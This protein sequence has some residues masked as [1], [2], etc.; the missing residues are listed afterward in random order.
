[1]T[2]PDPHAGSRRYPWRGMRAKPKAPVSTRA[3]TGLRA[4]RA[5][6]LPFVW[7]APCMSLGACCRAKEDMVA[8]SALR[9]CRGSPTD[10]TTVKIAG[11]ID[12]MPPTDFG[13]ASKVRRTVLRAI[14]C[15]YFSGDSEAPATHSGSPSPGV[16]SRRGR[17]R[18]AC[19]RLLRRTACKRWLASRAVARL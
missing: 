2:D 8:S 17:F 5:Q 6:A 18:G 1:M 11:G 9:L 10:D 15:K 14:N 13:A 7:S 3:Q 19:F 4:R 16:R 12:S